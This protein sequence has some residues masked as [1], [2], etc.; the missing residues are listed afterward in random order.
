MSQ[1][2][3]SIIVPIYN[4]EPYLRK[5]VESLLTQD[6]DPVEYEIILVD[7]GSTDGCSAICDEYAQTLHPSGGSRKGANIKVIHQ[8]NGGLSAAR[9]TG[10]MAAK[11]DYVCFVDSDDYW[12]PNVLGGLMAQVERDNLDVLRFKW[13]NVRVVSGLED[14]R[15]SG[16]VD[17]RYEVFNPNKS[18]PYRLEDYSSDVTTGVDFLNTRFGYACYAVQF[19]IRRSLLSGQYSVFSNQCSEVSAQYSEV[20]T[21]KSAITNNQLQI[22]FTPNLHFEDTD[23]M[24]RMLLAAQR[25]AST[26]TMVYDYLMREGSI[27]KV[28]ADLDKKRRNIEDSMLIVERLGG[29]LEQ[30]PKCV[31]LR[32][33]QSSMAAGIIHSVIATFPAERR[34]YVRRLRRWHVFPLVIANQG[35]TYARR[36]R[37]MNVSTWLYAI[38]MKWMRG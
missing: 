33:M 18:N 35:R 15:M 4:V 14:E 34:D 28:G 6:L 27:T 36:A 21:Q 38:V 25:V 3:L 31:W 22:L 20:S 5:C 26:D 7:D 30:H 37:I 10:I 12:E 11:G 13:Q 29:L 2:K 16:L 19:I 1:I 23:W 32:R 17:E 8:P 24:P 9:N